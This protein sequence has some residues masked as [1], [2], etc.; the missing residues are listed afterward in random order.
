MK[1][2]WRNEEIYGSFSLLPRFPGDVF[3]LGVG[4]SHFPLMS[5]EDK[6]GTVRHFMQSGAVLSVVTVACRDFHSFSLQPERKPVATR[7][8]PDNFQSFFIF[9]Q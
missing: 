1:I 9:I 3:R 6:G 7:N 2:L 5:V 8:I 4:N